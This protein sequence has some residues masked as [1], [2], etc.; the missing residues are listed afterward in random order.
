MRRIVEPAAFM[1]RTACLGDLAR[2]RDG[3]SCK[4]TLVPWNEGDNS[5]QARI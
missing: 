3:A 2:L 5:A 4:D 1:G